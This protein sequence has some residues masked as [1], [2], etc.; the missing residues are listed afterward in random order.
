[1]NLDLDKELHKHIDISYRNFQS[2]LIKDSNILGVRLP[3]IKKIANLVPNKEINNYIYNYQFQPYLESKILFSLFIGKADITYKMRC[4]F[5][6][7]LIK[8]TDNW[9]IC[10]SAAAHQKW[11]RK[12]KNAFLKEIDYYLQENSIWSQRFAYVCLLKYYISDEYLEQIYEFCSKRYLQSYYVQM[13]IAWL[14]C[15]ML[16][17]YPKRTEYF[18]TQNKIDSFTYKKVLQKAIES[19]KITSDKKRFTKHFYS[20]LF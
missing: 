2:K 6:K 9:E 15:E 18:L 13:A 20:R 16:V 17:K 10:D 11:I 14:L 8:H 12:N 5:L 3:I 1:M 4:Q 7:K 19:K